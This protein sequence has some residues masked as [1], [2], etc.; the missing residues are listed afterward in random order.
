M[1]R[2]ALLLCLAAPAAAE[3]PPRGEIVAVRGK[4]VTLRYDFADPAQLHDFEP[5][6]PPRLPGAT[7]GSAR[8]EGGRLILE[9]AAAVRYRL[10]AQGL[11]RVRMQLRLENG[12]DGGAM[13]EG[14]TAPLLLDLTDRRFY[15]DGGLLLSWLDGYSKSGFPNVRDVA[16]AARE[17]IELHLPPEG[18]ADVDLLADRGT[19]FVRVGSLYREGAAELASPRRLVLWGSGGKLSVDELELVVEMEDPPRPPR[20][21]ENEKEEKLLRTIRDAPLSAGAL[22]AARELSRRDVKAW[23][24][25]AALVREFAAKKAHAALPV[26]R[27]LGEGAEPERRAL[28]ADLYK[29]V[30]A[31]EVRFEIALELA[32]LYPENADLLHEQLKSPLEKRLG[33]FRA[34]VWRGLKEEVVRSCAGDALLAADA[35]EVLLARD[36]RPDRKHLPELAKTLARQGLSRRAG[37]AFLQEFT[38]EQDWDLV[39]ELIQLLLDPEFRDGAHLMLL[40]ISDKD[41]APDRDIWV[42]WMTAKRGAFKP[43]AVSDPGPVTA[44]ILRGRA[45]LRL[46]VIDDGAATWPQNA[47]WPGTRVGATALAVYALRAA[48]LPKDDAAIQNALKTTLLVWPAQGEP[49]LRDDLDGYTY[50]LSMLAMALESVDRNGMKAAKEAI[51]RRLSE[52]QLGNGQ[53]TY[54]CRAPGY[55][56]RPATGDNSNTQ[57]AILGLRSIKRCGIPVDTAVFERTRDFWL[58]ATNAYGGWGYGPKG[59]SL[60]EMSMTAAGIST[61]AICAEAI[62]GPEAVKEVGGNKFVGLGQRRLGELLL[63]DGFKEQEIYALYGVERACILTRTRAFNDFDWYREGAELLVRSQKESGAWGDNAARGVA[64]GQGYGEAVDT[65]FALLFLKRA[66]TGIVGAGENDTVVKVPEPRRPSQLK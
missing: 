65:A 10:P 29:R 6:E 16:R 48:G 4:T 31:P 60:H 13:I 19:V 59:A 5:A 27:A 49:A 62:R 15:K 33:L 3:G 50:A 37:L 46:E 66:T 44:A 14:S 34:L 55:G 22:L 12:G 61:L 51:A 32:D 56:D 18:N 1:R 45:A 54:N 28:L 57:F 25:L 43:P 58:T 53:W 63:N 42:S 41:L 24:K 39:T 26:V 64:L 11:L 47:D 38:A 23:E 52:G 7:A 9:G 8:V 20:P 40:S 2:L 21:L 30:K 35:R 36:A 17:A